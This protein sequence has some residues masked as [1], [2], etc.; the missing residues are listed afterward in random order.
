MSEQEE[1]ARV[2]G[3][4]REWIGTPYRD[5]AEIKGPAGG[6]DCAK[7]IKCVFE[8][9]GLVPPIEIPNYSPQWF[10]HQT[11]EL[12]M[13]RVTA[14]A[15]EITQDQAKPGDIVL[16]R[17][18]KCYAHGAI[19]IDPGWPNIIH[20]FYAARRVVRAHGLEGQL[21]RPKHVRKFFTRW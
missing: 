9:A 11:A 2:C 6:V 1:R 5:C 3:I 13:D 14:H 12:Y 15:R 17:M 21:G 4:A 10:L 18:G 16:Y 8:E 7:L 20:A 19:I